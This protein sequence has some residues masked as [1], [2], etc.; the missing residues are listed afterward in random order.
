MDRRKSLYLAF[1]SI[2]VPIILLII[3]KVA[4]AQPI[5][6][7]CSNTTM[8]ANNTQYQAKLNTLFRYL[9]SNTTN[10]SGYHQAASGNDNNE[11]EEV[12]GHFL[13][14]GDQN[15]SSCQDCVT[16]A[17]TT[18]LPNTCPNR[19]VAIMWYDYCMVRY[20]NQSFFGRMDESPSIMYWNVNNVTGNSTRFEQLLGNMLRNNIVVRAASGG[21]QKKFATDTVDYTSLQTIYGL[22]QC[23]PDLSASDCNRC[24][25]NGIGQ[26]MVTLGGQVL[27]PSCVIRYEINAFF[28]LSS[29]ATPPQPLPLPPRQ[30]PTGDS[31]NSES[32]VSAK[33]IIAIVVPVVVVLAALI[34]ICVCCAKYKKTKTH[35]PVVERVEDFTTVESLQYDLT[36]LQSATSNFSE[37]NKLGEGGFGGVY[38]KS[39]ISKEIGS[40]QSSSKSTPWS[41]N[42]VS[43]TEPE[44]R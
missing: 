1:F 5:F 6:H 37:E 15:T 29:L 26:L 39:K 44:P 43:I 42:D 9:S 32:N 7:D 36:T 24:L 41:I 14:R 11:S 10:P 2:Y 28:D 18:D 35:A 25:E 27:Q 4:Y 31:T 8:F 38:K 23:T 20:S 19:K 13:C 3:S 22:G 34:L 16:T 30:S 21:S 33:V 12:F 40:I 17:T